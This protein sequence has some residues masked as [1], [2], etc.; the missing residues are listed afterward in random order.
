MNLFHIFVLTCVPILLNGISSVNAVGVGV[1]NTT[2]LDTNFLSSAVNGVVDIASNLT[3]SLADSASPAAVQ[4]A[5]TLS[6]VT[7]LVQDL[8]G[9]QLSGP[10]IQALELVEYTFFYAVEFC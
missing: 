10:I 9:I 6:T 7:G 8:T 5:E 2:L 4:T 3:S 1:D